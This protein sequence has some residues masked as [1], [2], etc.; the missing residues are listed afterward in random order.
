MSGFFAEVESWLFGWCL[1]TEL[2]RIFP[3]NPRINAAFFS[4][5]AF[6]SKGAAFI[7]NFGSIYGVKLRAAF[8]WGWRLFRFNMLSL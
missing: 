3:Y 1:S 7:G 4:G 8:I 6:Y 2:Y 5:Y